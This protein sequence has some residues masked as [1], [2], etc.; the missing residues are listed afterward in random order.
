MWIGD[1]KESFVYEINGND[2]IGKGKQSIVATKS[3]KQRQATAPPQKQRSPSPSPSSSS[4][5]TSEITPIPISS[6]KRS[7]PTDSRFQK[8]N[9]KRPKTRD[10]LVEV[11]NGIDLLCKAVGYL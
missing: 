4:D 7:A 3:Q 10:E 11:K 1:P 6:R 8:D 2:M 9:S 5:A